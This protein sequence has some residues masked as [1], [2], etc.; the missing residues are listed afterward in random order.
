M[1]DASHALQSMTGFGSA[2]FEV[3]GY[4]YRVQVRTVNHRHLNARFSMPGEFAVAESAGRRLLEER[5]GR[6]AIQ[7]TVD[8]E[9][10]GERELDVR[11]DKVGANKLMAALE[12]MAV[13]IGAPTPG[14][15]TV[16]KLG[17]F[18][19]LRGA[20]IPE[21]P[22]KEAFLGGLDEALAGVVEMRLVE[23]AALAEDLSSRLD[24]LDRLLERVE[25]AAP[26]VREGFERR[27]R[28]RVDEA[29]RRQGVEPDEGRL[30]TEL[31]MFAER[32]DVTEETVRARTHVGAF[33]RLLDP[34]VEIRRGKRL[35]FLAQEL[36][37]EFNTIGSKCRDAGM[38]EDVVDAKVELERI[39]EQVQN[40]A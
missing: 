15:D 23:G 37:R 32:V 30:V 28:D 40:I 11:V 13:S 8:L 12:E 27:L 36:N 14:L 39:R 1:T 2:A 22:L 6:G 10:A 17:E 35:D 19:V 7:V 25:E 5:L 29:A 20:G 21:E 16:L 31:V 4:R 9:E 18:V 33:R 3:E 38:A 34:Q 26:V 24:A